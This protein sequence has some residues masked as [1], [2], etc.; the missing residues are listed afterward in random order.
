MIWNDDDVYVYEEATLR[1]MR[2]IPCSN[3]AACERALVGEVESGQMAVRGLRAKLLGI[4]L[5]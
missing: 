1:V 5:W 4:E 3:R 2:V